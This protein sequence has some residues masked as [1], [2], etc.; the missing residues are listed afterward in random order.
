MENKEIVRSQ[1]NVEISTNGKG[2][3]SWKVKAYADTIE[4]AIALAVEADA[5][6]AAKL[7]EGGK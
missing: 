2:E 3:K 5:K 4:E 7:A 1:S 6:V